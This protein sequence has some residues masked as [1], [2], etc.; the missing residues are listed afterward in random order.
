MT[1]KAVKKSNESYERRIKNKKS[2]II[3]K[4]EKEYDQHNV[5]RKYCVSSQEPR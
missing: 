4:F 2:T 1:I 3:H 5:L